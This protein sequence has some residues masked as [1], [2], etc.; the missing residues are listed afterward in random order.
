[1]IS[2]RFAPAL[3]MAGRVLLSSLFI[4]AGINK[5]TDYAGTL[6]YMA[7]GGL[8]V[9]ALLLPLVILLELGGGLAIALALPVH[10]IAALALAAFTLGANVL[11][12]DFWALTGGEA[13]IQLS[14]F[15]KNVAVAGGLL[16][17]AARPLR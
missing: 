5:V 10:R 14:L 3:A 11:F 4:L 9:P 7:G 2:D 6:A 16:L 12:H 1:M 8:P 15:V 13:Q 17:I